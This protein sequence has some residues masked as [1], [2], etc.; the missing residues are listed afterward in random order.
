MHH[1]HAPRIITARLRSHTFTRSHV[2]TAG[3]HAVVIGRSN[4]V[5]V[6]VANLLLQHNA[7]VTVCHSRTPNIPDL[8]RQADIVVAA[9]GRPEFVQVTCDV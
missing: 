4:I 7:T 2:H 9:I 1:H 8:C 5:G 3:K 6:P